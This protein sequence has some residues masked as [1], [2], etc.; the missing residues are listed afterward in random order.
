MTA[1]GKSFS[2]AVQ[3]ACATVTLSIPNGTQSANNIKRLH[4]SVKKSIRSRPKMRACWSSLAGP[5]NNVASQQSLQAFSSLHRR[6]IE[7]PLARRKLREKNIIHNRYLSLMNGVE[8]HE[9][10]N[11]TNRYDRF[12]GCLFMAA[13]K[14]TSLNHIESRNPASS[15]TKDEL[16]NVAKCSMEILSSNRRSF[17]RTWTRMS[18]LVEFVIDVCSNAGEEVVGNKKGFSIA[19]IGC[20]HGILSLSIACMAGVVAQGNGQS[21]FVSKVVGADLS[22][23]ALENGALANFRRVNDV[24]SRKNGDYELNEILQHTNANSLESMTENFALENEETGLI[25]LNNTLPIEFR[26]GDGLGSLQIGEADGVILAGMGVHTMVDILFGM[27]P[28]YS[29]GAEQKISLGVD[30]TLR[31]EYFCG[32]LP[33]DRLRTNYLFLQPTNS[34]P[35]HLLLLYDRLHKNGSWVLKDEKIVFVGGHW[36]IS[37]LL[38]RQHGSKVDRISG[39]LMSELNSSESSFRFPGYFLN[40]QCDDVYKSYVLHHLNWLK[41][42]FERRDG[43]LEDNDQRWV[44]YLLS[45]ENKETWKSAVSW[46]LSKNT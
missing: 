19:D 21:S 42:D 27:A 34:R 7:E 11:K 5:Q 41:Q 2:T 4:T 29:A 22:L 3:H 40:D 17:N 18:P 14:R 32:D 8:D 6:S 46:F 12:R 9:T 13:S 16:M 35:R 24:M 30:E 43:L 10:K 31:S 38:E 45:G 20:D 15:S 28:G 25:T 39:G 23:Q 26:I 37:L 1:M 44:Q 36:Y 33:L